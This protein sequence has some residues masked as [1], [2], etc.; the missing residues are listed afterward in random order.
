MVRTVYCIQYLQCIATR[1]TAVACL[2]VDAERFVN[3]E[4][5]F[6]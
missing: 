6:K 3:K 1:N 4:H 2:L 5:A